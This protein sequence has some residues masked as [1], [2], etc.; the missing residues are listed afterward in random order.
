MARGTLGRHGPAPATLVKVVVFT[1]LASFLTYYIGAQIVGTRFGDRYELRAS[2]DDV[3]GLVANDLVKVSGAPVGK[4][5]GVRV[6]RGR[7]EVTMTVDRGV[8]LPADSTA[9]IR[10]RNLVG[11]RMIYLMPGNAQSGQWLGNGSRITATKAVVDLGEIVNTLGPLTR[12]LDPAQLN[13][14]LQAVAQMLDGNS[15]SLNLMTVD[16]QHVVQTFADRKDQLTSILDSY[17]T[18][19][20]VAVKRDGQISQM[21]DDLVAISEAFAGNA[22]LLGSASGELAQVSR[23]LDQ[24]IG[25][26]QRELDRAIANLDAFARTA[27]TNVDRLETIIQGLPPALRSLFTVVNGGHYL[28]VNAMCLNVVQ[29]SCPTPMRL[30]GPENKTTE[31][32]MRDGGRTLRSLLAQ[33]SAQGGTR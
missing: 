26:N 30:P 19:T 14:I 2:F 21:I 33:L 10:W 5:T 11:Q 27:T 3:G 18:L 31:K 24:V 28:R 22:D 17:S 13:K 4:V 29:G 12:N 7:A 1:I 32:E 23:T 20:N 8:R 6:V 16:L 25:G 15:D 9:E